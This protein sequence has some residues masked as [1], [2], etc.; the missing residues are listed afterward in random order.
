[1][2]HVPL[3]DDDQAREA[4]TGQLLL[5][6]Y[7]LYVQSAENVTMKL[8]SA[9]RF[10]LTVLAGLLAL[11]SLPKDVVAAQFQEV[12]YAGIGLLGVVLCVVW[13]LNL[14]SY[15]QL[16]RGKYKIIHEIEQRLPAAPFRREWDVLGH[17]KDKTRYRPIS[18]LEQAIP[19]AFLLVY[20][21]LFVYY[22]PLALATLSTLSH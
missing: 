13:F 20:L 22:L 5:E 12:L 17:G 9:S 8:A 19:V 11:F 6:Q 18:E 7:K 2:T 4:H 16:N 1:M 3:H 14:H 15:R 21:A 10:Y